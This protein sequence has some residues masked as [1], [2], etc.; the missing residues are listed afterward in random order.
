MRVFVDG[1]AIG[2]YGAVQFIELDDKPHTVTFESKYCYPE[3][4]E[5]SP[6]ALAGRLSRSHPIDLEVV[7]S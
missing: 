4:I 2:D 7:L 1:K 6:D 3:T 5:I